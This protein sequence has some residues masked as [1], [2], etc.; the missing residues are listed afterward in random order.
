MASLVEIREE[1]HARRKE[2]HDIW[3]QAGPDRDFGRV[4]LLG[5]GDTATKVNEFRRRDAVINELA[6]EEQQLAMA[7]MIAE[8]NAQE[9]KRGT[10]PTGTFVHGGSTAPREFRI[11]DLKKSLVE[12]KGYRDFREGRMR[13][14]T[15]ELP[16]VDWKTL[17]TLSTIN[18]QA[19]RGPLVEMGME[20][21]NISDLMLSSNTDANT[22]EYYEETTFTNAAAATSEGSAKPEST[23]GYTLRTESVR[24]IAHWIPATKEALD[25]VS[26]LEG[27][28]RGRL[29]FG[30]TRVEEAQL[31]SGDG[32][33]P[34]ISGILD[35]SG[36]QTQA[37][38]S[39]PTPDAIYK[40]MQKIRGAGGSGYAEPTAV[41]F[42]PN[43][44][45][46]IKL[47]RTV[48]G[49][50]IW[51]NPS[52][53]GPDRIWGLPVRQTTAMP[54]GTALAGA[55][56]PYAEVIRREGVTVTL[57][58]EHASFF[59]ENKVAILA[60]SRLALAIYRPAAFCTVTGL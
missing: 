47:L 18:R 25:D 27:Q 51:G 16:N 31:I 28:I 50:Y 20:D 33:A 56:R 52:D 54:E 8:K 1:L 19:L 17:V 10:E 3:E 57:S 41:I 9:M 26:F 15:L 22:L 5:A 23:L 53:E 45:T 40:G 35:R 12:S 2:M 44:W 48:D 42:N 4:T 24:K 58:T 38:G 30:V 55:F 43:N 59:T 11:T 21:R 49:V 36:L 60:E 7:E 46:A 29:A 14:V 13:S 6:A 32:T 37:K 34:N 39:D